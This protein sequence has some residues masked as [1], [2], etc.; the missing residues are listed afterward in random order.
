MDRG[1]AILSD[2]VVFLWTDSVLVRT[3]RKK[4]QRQDADGG[5]P[6][7]RDLGCCYSTTYSSVL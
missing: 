6:P 7:A 5:R 3:E 2:Q 4:W 1:S